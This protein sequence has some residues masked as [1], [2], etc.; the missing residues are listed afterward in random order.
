MEETTI[1]TKKNILVYG[2]ILGS[3]LVIYGFSR[4]ITGNRDTANWAY[5][6]FEL[7]LYIGFVFY[8]IYKYKSQNHGF[9]TLWQA[10]KVGFGITFISIVMQKI[11]DIFFVEVISAETIQEMFN[12]TDYLTAK[13]SQERNK[14]VNKEN[15]Y[16]INMSITLILYLVLGVIIS[17]FAGAIM[18]KNRNPF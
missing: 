8:G 3:I 6:I 12:S 5:S 13:E 11:G 2:L 10:L 14:T 4:H 16:L 1:S 7:F 17:L 18:Q 15:D 9:L